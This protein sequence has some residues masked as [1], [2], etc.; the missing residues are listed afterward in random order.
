MEMKLPKNLWFTIL[1]SLPMAAYADIDA[2]KLIKVTKE[3]NQK[4][5][6]YYM[7]EGEI[8]CSL[9]LLSTGPIDPALLKSEKQKIIFDSRPWQAVWGEKTDEMTT[10]EYVPAGDKIEN[11]KELVTTQYVP[12]MQ[13]LSPKDYMQGVVDNLQKTGFNPEIKLLV[14]TPDYVLFE[15]R[16][17]SPSNFQQD[18]LQ[19]ITKKEDGFYLLHYVIKKPDMGEQERKKWINNL[20]NSS[21]NE[22]SVEH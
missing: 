4:C 1:L 20:K 6:E 2:S 18:E 17:L 8:Y 11:W 19:K 15:F 12:G 16:V 7:M 14:E 5:V 13:L 3:N 21:V 22:S 9:T 10:I